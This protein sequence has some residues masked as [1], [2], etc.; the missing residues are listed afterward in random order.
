MAEAGRVL[1]WVAGKPVRLSRLA[2][3][4][5]SCDATVQ[6][7][8]VADGQPVA[9]GDVVETVPSRVRAAVVA[10][11]G[12]CRFPG[13]DA[14]AGWSDVH[15]I[16]PRA[17]GGDHRAENLVLL[18]RRCHRRVDTRG[19]RI[20]FEPDGVLA[21]AWRGRRYTTHPRARPPCD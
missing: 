17:R 16:V 21:F 7:I 18:C 5:L 3:R 12:G 1:A 9:V 2:T 4:T 14:P 6:P 19:W 13:C 8:V 10:R 20:R 15:H 11:D